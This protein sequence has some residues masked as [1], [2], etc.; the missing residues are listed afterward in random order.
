MIAVSKSC[1]PVC[2]DVV[3][4]FNRQN[5]TTQELGQRSDSG[6]HTHSV[7]FR[8]RGRHSNL[9]PVDL[10]EV[11]D[12]GIK[13][14]L[15]TKFSTTLLKALV[16]MVDEDARAANTNHMPSESG[17]SY[18]SQPESVALSLDSSAAGSVDVHS[19]QSE[20]IKSTHQ[21]SHERV[22]TWRNNESSFS[23]ESQSRRS[24]I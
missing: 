4:M 17:S 2:W 15:L 23:L 13:D 3:E 9:Y 1:C 8:A 24:E 19:T 14:Q 20:Y 21:N 7:R 6:N 16:S 22:A 18:V 10:P 11:L 5:P 12:E